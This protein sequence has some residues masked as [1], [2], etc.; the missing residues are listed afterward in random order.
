MEKDKP[1]SQIEL[2]MEKN[3]DSGFLNYLRRER[4]KYFADFKISSRSSWEKVY[5]GCRLAIDGLGEIPYLKK[6]EYFIDELNQVPV[7]DLKLAPLLRLRDEAKN[8][9]SFRRKKG[10]QADIGYYYWVFSLLPYL[11]SKTRKPH[12]A[13][14]AECIEIQEARKSGHVDISELQRRWAKIIESAKK[15]VKK[16]KLMGFVVGSESS[17][18]YEAAFNYAHWLNSQRKSQG[19][20]PLMS[21]SKEIKVFYDAI[22]KLFP[23]RKPSKPHHFSYFASDDYLAF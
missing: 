4:K 19:L 12:W 20:K 11:I 5:K 1:K 17:P 21:N 9:A 10:G 7:L 6:Q 16:T 15:S 2:L 8:N 22:Y 23:F 18:P 14:I 3:G 13:A